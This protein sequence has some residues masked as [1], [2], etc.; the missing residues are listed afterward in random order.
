MKNRVLV[1]AVLLVALLLPFKQVE[2]CTGIRLIANDGSVVYGR[3]MEWGSFDLNTR[4]VIIPQDFKFTALTPEGLN[5]KEY[6]AKYGVV[7]LDMIST[8]YISDGMNE[9]GLAVGMYYHPNQAHYNEFIP[10]KKGNTIGS[11]DVPN[12]IL[13]QFS[14]VEEVIDGMNEVI[15]T[16]I[17]EPSVNAEVP[18][19]WMVSDASGKSVV[20]E[21]LKG[22]LVIHDAPL[23]VITN[24]PSYDWHIQNLSNYI[25]LSSTQVAKK[26]LNGETILATGAGS[27]MLGLP[28][29]NTPASRFVRAVAWTQT[30][31]DMDNGAEALYENFRIL[32]NFN[33][34]YGAGSAEGDGE[35]NAN[36]LMRSSTI[37]T[38]GWNLTDLTLNYHTQHNRRVRTLDLKSINFSKLGKE[39]IYI[40]LDKTK[41]QDF[42]EIKL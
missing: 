31:R 26:E 11:L 23:G 2:A 10:S 14:T 22:E 6:K 41:E 42:D 19:H 13:T 40:P 29:D 25:N 1:V 7:G 36:D 34:P 4:I 20:I 27:G 39:I 12:Y 5:G 21:Y 37:W 8:Y 35:S 28:G 3:S 18:S 30:T 24:A 15:V 16:G 38:S 17:Y 33:L 32:D 9:K